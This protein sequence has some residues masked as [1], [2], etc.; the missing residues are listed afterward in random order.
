MDLDLIGSHRQGLVFE[1]QSLGLKS[2]RLREASARAMR[3]QLHVMWPE[4]RC[5]EYLRCGHGGARKGVSKKADA[6]PRNKS[7]DDSTVSDVQLRLRTR[8]V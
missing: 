4:L 8:K 2:I 7:S 6:R 5:R 1:V 3:T